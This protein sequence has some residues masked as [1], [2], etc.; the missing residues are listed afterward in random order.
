MSIA[1]RTA[2]VATT[3]DP[4]ATPTTI[5]AVTKRRPAASAL[6]LDNY[7]KLAGAV[8]AGTPSFVYSPPGGTPGSA[9]QPATV[10]LRW[11]PPDAPGN[12]KLSVRDESGAQIWPQDKS[13]R[14]TVAGATGELLSPELREAL[15]A[16]QTRKQRGMLTLILTT[17]E[18]DDVSVRFRVTSKEEDQMLRQQIAECNKEEGLLPYICRSYWYSQLTLYTEA[19]AEYEAA[20]KDYAPESEELMRHAMVAQRLTGNY[21]REKAL[22]SQLPLPGNATQ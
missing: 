13:Q 19:A 5:L 21:K 22:E 14:A 12:L 3:I 7:F 20:L 6:P 8:R 18:G 15:A 4:S 1:S 9:V 10:V 17:S 11:V 2:E 16:Y